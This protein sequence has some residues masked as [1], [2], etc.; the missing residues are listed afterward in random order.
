MRAEEGRQ[1]TTKGI[2]VDAANIDDLIIMDL[3]GTD[4]DE[5]GEDRTVLLFSTHITT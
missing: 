1:Q 3:E 2:W 5:R 4:S